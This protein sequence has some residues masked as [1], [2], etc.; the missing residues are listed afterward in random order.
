MG[1]GQNC[2]TAQNCTKILIH[3][4][5]F[6]TRVNFARDVI[7][8]PKKNIKNRIQKKLL[9]NKLKLKKINP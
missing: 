3:K 9:L 4:D 5:K 8:A 7:F 6:A 2:M 1:K